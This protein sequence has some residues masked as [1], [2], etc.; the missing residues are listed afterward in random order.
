MKR[1]NFSASQV[2]TEFSLHWQNILPAK[3]LFLRWTEKLWV[4]YH[5]NQKKHVWAHSS[6][7]PELEPDQQIKS[8]GLWSQDWGSPQLVSSVNIFFKNFLLKWK[9][10]NIDPETDQISQNWSHLVPV[11]FKTVLVK[12]GFRWFQSKPKPGP[13]LLPQPYTN[14]RD[15]PYLVLGFLTVYVSEQFFLLH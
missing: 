3:P 4:I 8:Y 2:V 1:E 11:Q 10:S 5:T 7:V 15:Y 12:S 13:C 9:N 14:K 6:S